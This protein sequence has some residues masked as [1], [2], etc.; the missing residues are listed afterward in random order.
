M[1]EAVEALIGRLMTDEAFRQQF[2]ADPLGTLTDLRTAGAELTQTEIAAL[3][4]T[5]RA[6]WILAAAEI[7]PRLQ[8]VA[9][10]PQKEGVR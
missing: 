1:H 3:V 9:L 4:F 2:L 10:S 7:D 5:N 8:K 6:L